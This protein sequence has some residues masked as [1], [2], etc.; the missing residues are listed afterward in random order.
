MT[1]HIRSSDPRIL[2]RKCCDRFRSV[3]AYWVL[4]Q[5]ALS[6]PN[7]VRW[8]NRSI[9]RRP[10]SPQAQGFRF[11]RFYRHPRVRHPPAK[12]GLKGVHR[13]DCRRQA[14]PPFTA[15]SR[16]GGYTNIVKGYFYT[17]LVGTLV[18]GSKLVRVGEDRPDCHRRPPRRTACGEKGG[19]G[20]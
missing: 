1:R 6:S 7:I 8:L 11:A 16:Q 3:G 17:N 4:S 12:A 14:A 18:G 2:T 19:S 5:L 9:S 13:Q 15:L 20:S 10:P